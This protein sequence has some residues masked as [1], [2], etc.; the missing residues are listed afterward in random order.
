MRLVPTVVA[1]CLGASLAAAPQATLPGW[2]AVLAGYRDALSRAGI[3]GSTLMVMRDGAVVERDSEGLQDLASRTA[4]GPGTIYH[5]ASITKTFTGIAIMQLRDRGLLSLDDPVIKYVP[6]LRL[7]HDPF[8]DM[9]ADQDSP[10]DVAQRG[11]PRRDL[12][13]GRRSALASVRADLAGNNWWRCCPTPRSSS[14]RA[15]ATAIRIPA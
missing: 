5:W 1:A 3:V 4:V 12:A 8:G 10:P 14:R 13:V 9:S 11:L 15:R 2:P 7:V 6:E